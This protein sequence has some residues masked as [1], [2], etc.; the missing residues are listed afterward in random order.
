MTIEIKI[1]DLNKEVY[2]FWEHEQNLILDSY[3]LC[4]RESKR[5]RNWEYLKIYE[6]LSGRISNITENE[7]PFTDEIK[8]LALDEYIKLLKVKT[9]SEYKNKL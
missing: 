9:W 1:D 8:K 6:R 2:R 5:K 7:V 4:L 3:Y